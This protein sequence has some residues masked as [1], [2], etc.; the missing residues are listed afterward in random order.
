MRGRCRSFRRCPGAANR[1][2]FRPAKWTS[3]RWR[4][5]WR[6]ADYPGR[7][8]RQ[9]PYTCAQHAVVVSEAVETLAGLKL[10]GAARAGDAC[11]ARGGPGCRV[12]GQKTRG[13][14]QKRLALRTIDL[15]ALAD[16]L[17]HTSPWDASVAPAAAAF[18]ECLRSL[19]ALT[20]ENR[21]RLALCA[22][23]A[24]TVLAGLGMAV[25]EAALKDAGLAREVPEWW[26]EALR[27]IRRMADAAVRR[28]LQ[29]PALGEETAFPA[30]RKRIE[31]V[32]RSEAAKRWLARYRALTAT[33]EETRT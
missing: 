12:A 33:T 24:E 17:A 9:K 10:P 15:E 6:A 16:V 20:A 31:P 25:A 19:G 11:L 18:D 14:G 2:F 13:R 30:T 28:D 1:R 22:L 21:R 8:R 26:V 3:R 5:D 23:L 29:G 4:T 7:R 32:E 27:F